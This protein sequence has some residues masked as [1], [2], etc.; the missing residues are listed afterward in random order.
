MIPERTAARP[1][2]E[3]RVCCEISPHG[4]PANAD[5]VQGLSVAQSKFKL[6]QGHA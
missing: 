2:A 4:N 5:R 6:A 3:R 1:D